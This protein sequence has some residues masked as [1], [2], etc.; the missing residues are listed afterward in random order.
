MLVLLLVL[1]IGV[2]IGRGSGGLP[3]I[4]A[5]PDIAAPSDAPADFDLFWQAYELLKQNFVDQSK[6]TDEDL[7]QGAIRGMVDALGDT[8]HSVY[9]TKDQVQAEQDALSGHISGI[10]VVVDAR[11]GTP[12]VV[13]VIDG[14]PAA[15]AGVQAGDLILS[16]DGTPTDHQ[17]V[18]PGRRGGARHARN[19]GHVTRPASRR[20]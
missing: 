16:V 2:G 20:H 4:G 12:L 5:S 17:T 9:L 19:L 11:S 8:G 13:S 6:L 10:G 18:R 7:T 1:G 15:K 14:A 3:T